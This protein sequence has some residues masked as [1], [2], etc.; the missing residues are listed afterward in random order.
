MLPGSHCIIIKTRYD[1]CMQKRVMLFLIP[2][3]L[4][5]S[6]IGV[7]SFSL[8]NQK[9]AAVTS[10]ET[11]VKAGFP[12][13][14]T[15]PETCKT[16]EG[17]SFINTQGNI[18]KYSGEIILDNP[19]PNQKITSPL[20]VKG[21]ARGSWF[22]EGQMSAEL[23]DIHN[24]SLGRVILEAQGNWQTDNL[25]PFSGG[26]IFKKGTTSRADLK[27]RNDNP[28]GLPQNQKEIIIPVTL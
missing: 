26:L 7:Y 17:K 22:F 1:G 12:T 3:C 15:Y 14:A 8:S 27:I 13:T 23:V 2:L 18:S 6:V 11:C 21:K 9:I 16:P 4:L 28:S 20:F 5:I 24:E 25:V 19:T 10:Y